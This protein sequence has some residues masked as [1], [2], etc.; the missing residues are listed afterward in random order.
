MIFKVF[1]Q[2]FFYVHSSLFK[3][4]KQ[5]FLGSVGIIVI[6]YKCNG[7]DVKLNRTSRVPKSVKCYRL[8]KDRTLIWK[9]PLTNLVPPIN[10]QTFS[11]KKR[12]R[13]PHCS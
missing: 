7:L 1:A 2:L 11:Q 6:V 5:T 10:I 12:L 13:S 3:M 4:I 9:L 8:D